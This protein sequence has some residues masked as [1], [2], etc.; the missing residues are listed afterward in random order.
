M[1]FV[2][3]AGKY[4]RRDWWTILMLAALLA[5]IL[6]TGRQAPSPD[7][8]PG[9]S[10]S[11]AASDIS[12][13]GSEI[14]RL[15]TTE[16]IQALEDRILNDPELKAKFA[17][18]VLLM[19][20]LIAVGL[21]WGFLFWSSI[22][23]GERWMDR[24]GS[25]R[26]GWGMNDAFRAVVLMFFLD[27]LLS[28]VFSYWLKRGGID[29]IN[30]AFMAGALVRSAV[31]LFCL[32]RMIR[33]RGMSWEDLGLCLKRPWRQAFWGLAGYL[34]MIP[35]YVLILAV[36]TAVL[37]HFA[38]KAPV[39]TPVQMLFTEASVL[40]VAGFVLFMGVLGPWFEEILFRGYVYPAFKS[41]LGVRYGI[42]VSSV[43]FAALHGHGIAF[44][45]ILVLGITLHLLYE[46][47]GSI[48]PGAV[49]HM[50]HNSAMLLLT[51][52]IRHLT[53]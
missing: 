28:S 47:S 45:P 5:A 2:S 17:A 24:F 15:R 12:D 49:L 27:L 37:N 40:N 48:L 42:L 34:A 16:K 46:R 11:S 33:R 3:G 38:I 25:P 7:A 35:I 14:A 36:M 31:I 50:T 23:R 19:L 20:I 13:P 53:S 9:P 4:L 8:D 51:L 1:T 52:G 41:R 30:M 26:P 10:P 21:V 44:A 29:S 22:R 32:D 43:L 6:W 18:V 39:Q